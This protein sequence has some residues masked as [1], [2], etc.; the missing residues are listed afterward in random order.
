MGASRAHCIFSVE[1]LHLAGW[2]F[3]AAD[4]DE[5][6]E[7]LDADQDLLDEEAEE[8]AEEEEDPSRCGGALFPGKGNR[9]RSD[10]A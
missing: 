7:D 2:E 3:G 4:A 10:E 9:N 6:D 5:E 8:E 1:R